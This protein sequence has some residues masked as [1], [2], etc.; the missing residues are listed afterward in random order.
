[1]KRSQ[2]LS[3]RVVYEQDERGWWVASVADIPGCHTQGRS[4]ATAKRRI[5]EAIE[6]CTGKWQQG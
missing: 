6:V 4:F 2:V 5:A 1:M 3:Y